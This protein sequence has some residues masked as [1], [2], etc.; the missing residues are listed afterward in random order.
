MRSV[1]FA[2]KLVVPRDAEAAARLEREIEL[3][4]H[5]RHE[6]IVQYLGAASSAGD[7]YILLE[8]CAGGSVRRLLETLHPRGLP[9]SLLSTY[10]EQLLRGLH[11]LHEHMVIHRDLKGENLLFATDERTCAPRLGASSLAPRSA[12]APLR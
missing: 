12:W 6:H 9:A 8:Y 5:L 3:M 2:A 10:G 1:E 7:R 11:F 4:R